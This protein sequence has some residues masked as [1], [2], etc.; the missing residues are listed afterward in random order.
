MTSTRT[1]L[2]YEYYSLQFCLPKNGTFVYKSE[3]LGEVLRGDR[4]VNTPYEL[5]LLEN[6][7]CR[8]LCNKPSQP[9]NWNREQSY[10]V[11]ERIQDEY[12]VHLLVDNLPVA[13][14]IVNVDTMEVQFEPGYR[15][16][17][18]DKNQ[19]FINNHLKFILSYHKHQDKYRV[20]GFEVETM[21]V[22]QNDIKFEGTACTIPDSPKPQQVETNTET[23]LYFTYS[24]EWKESP[25]KWASRWD[26]YLAMSNVQ[27]HWFSII[28]SLVVVFF[29]SG[30][31]AL[32]MVKVLRREIAK[33]NSL[34]DGS[35]DA[36]EEKG[37]KLVHGDVFRPPRHTRFFAA[38]IGSGIQIF[39]M[40]L[41]TICK[42]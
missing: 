22:N 20:V 38:V 17:Q 41:I 27:I 26:I 18:V 31:L 28:N 29:L 8:L 7:E 35:D 39:L 25:V 36:L 23:Q 1:Q 10:K 42:N 33:Y 32:I 2:P 19:I 4:V 13:T 21:S 6:V 9:L 11:A 30:I 40:A 12:F 34:D 15:L 37:W 16:G 3:N 24:V 5:R 14:R